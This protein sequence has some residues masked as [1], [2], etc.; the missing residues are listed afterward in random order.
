MWETI[1]YNKWNF[2]SNLDNI[3]LKEWDWA[4]VKMTN[5]LKA[6]DSKGKPIDTNSFY[7]VEGDKVRYDVPSVLHYLRTLQN[8]T[9]SEITSKDT[10]SWINAVQIALETLGKD[11][12]KID[13]VMGR[14]TRHAIIEFQEDNGLIPNWELWPD[15]LKKLVSELIDK[16]NS[17]TPHSPK[18]NPEVNKNIIP[19]DLKNYRDAWEKRIV[20]VNDESKE[21]IKKAAE[22]IPLKIEKDSDWSNLI[23]LKLWSKTYKILDPNLEN[24]SDYEYMLYHICP[25]TRN[26]KCTVFSWWMR[27]DE[28]DKWENQA[29]KKYVKQQQWK[30]LHI[31]KIEEMSGLLDNLWEVAWLTSKSE[32]V[33]ALMYLTWMDWDYWLSMWNNENSDSKARSRSQLCCGDYY[34]YG[35]GYSTGDGYANASLCMISCK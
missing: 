27:W 18:S 8:K 20:W 11:V 3:L 21:K 4:K 2:E 16:L 25:I 30:W 7:S 9:W 32:K 5:T 1:V 34:Y 14:Q 19:E 6:L 33:A 17:P 35:F 24:H 12:W 15:T 28:E 13:G 23:E 26:E 10:T 22:Q 31:A 29:L